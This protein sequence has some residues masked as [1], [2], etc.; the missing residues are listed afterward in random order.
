MNLRSR[1]G[2]A[3]AAA[4]AVALLVPQAALAAEDG[5]GHYGG[6]NGSGQGG[7]GQGGGGAGEDG[8]KDGSTGSIYSDLVIALRDAKGVP[9]LKEYDVPATEEEEAT[10]E[11]CVQPVSYEPVPGLTAE[12]NPVDQ[13]DV[14]V[15]PLQGEWWTAPPA[16]GLP[17]EEI[18]T[19]DPQPQYAMFVHEAELERL[20]MARTA[21]DVIARKQADV[22]EKLR[23]G[24][25]V[26]LEAA[27][28]ITIDGEMLD[29]SPEYAGIYQSLMY[30]GTIPGLQFHV[31]TAN[32]DA[33]KAAPPA[34]I[35]PD[36]TT[37]GYRN[38]RFDAWELAATAIGVAASK[39]M[40]I[41]L[42]AVIYYNQVIGF[43]PEETTAAAA[44]GTGGT[45]G[46]PSTEEP[47]QIDEDWLPMI[48]FVED[49]T[50]KRYVDYTGFSYN[51]ADTFPGS[52]TILNVDKMRWEVKPYIGT[53]PF[54]NLSGDK[55]PDT[56]TLTGVVAFAQLADDVRSLINYYHVIE[57][58]PG[59]YMD[60]VG[61]DTTAAQLKRIT[62]PAVDLGT[63]PSAVFPTEPFPVTASL[64]NPWGGSVIEQTNLKVTVDAGEAVLDVG[65][66]TAVS[67]P[68]DADPNSWD[69]PFEAVSGD[70]V[71]YWGPAGGFQ[72]KPGDKYVT[73]F[74]AK[75]AA[76]APVGDYSVTLELVGDPT[77]ATPE[78]GI[79]T[80]A[81]DT[82]TLDVM[83]NAP[84]V[85][86]GA[87][88]PKLLTQA[89]Q[90][91]LP[92]RVYEPTPAPAPEPEATTTE[93]RVLQLTITGPDD[94]GVATTTE[95][96]KATDVRIYGE[97]VKVTQTTDSA[98]E[99]D[100][101][102]AAEA[103]PVTDMARMTLAP[104]SDTTDNKLVG[105]W[106][107]PWKVGYSD[108]LWYVSVIDGA[109][110]GTYQFDL[111]L[112]GVQSVKPATQVTTV[113]A[114]AEHGQKPPGTGEDDGG[115]GGGPVTPPGNGS[116]GGGEGDD[117][118]DD[119]G[120]GDGGG[121]P[122]TPP[123][124]G[125]DGPGKGVHRAGGT[126]KIATGVLLSQ[127]RFDD[128]EADAAVIARSDDY[129]DA[130]AAIPLVDAENATLLLAGSSLDKRVLD[131]VKRAVAAN[132]T[133]YIVGGDKAVSPKVEAALK[134]TGRKVVR[135]AGTTRYA[136]AVKVAGA[137]GT[138][139]AILLATGRDFA[140]ALAGGTAAAHLDGV[141]LLTDG[142]VM[143]KATAGYLAQHRTKAAY[144]L[145]GPA[146]AAAPKA[147]RVVGTDRYDTA[148]RVA[149]RFF[150]NP[151]GASVAAGTRFED[152]LSGGADAAA[153]GWPLLLTMPDR[154]HAATA[155]Y[156]T[157][158]RSI[159]AVDVY[160]GPKA[161][162]EQVATALGG[163]LTR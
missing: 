23:L 61:I 143:P 77:E 111:E 66:V 107:V 31:D 71:G 152:A 16:G 161:I 40:P 45:G 27:G 62:D 83:A 140:D 54:L 1:G 101:A 92:V 46:S 142:K 90:L 63:L 99:A 119:D 55:N 48:K 129:A 156:V 15:I 147:T 3:L 38:S 50:G 76:D 2:G 115:D 131:E 10:T 150:K 73:T 70:L 5:E 137:L 91:Q 17:V 132:G 145:G 19:C 65:D 8:G 13:R 68:T 6:G 24:S 96:L 122:A 20:N 60:P 33:P 89:A 14:Y 149:Q 44:E 102:A 12:K 98:A 84:T 7:G 162:H 72:V 47:R 64:F 110:V 81:T 139:K 49:T 136:T 133:V 160:G 79:K 109:P 118:D 159:A 104:T 130:L 106:T 80:L 34:E 39:T 155:K 125:S 94:D 144:A 32:P 75:L 88:I 116:G 53:V 59:I 25:D 158:T 26:A 97:Q 82:D 4:L 69:L 120:D 86:W 67:R 74:D 148:V 93:D 112:L 78:A 124:G 163:C 128:G 108:I 117:G 138:P 134:A 146:A 135:L 29:A 151:A 57:G 95:Q 85:L 43:P 153:Q 41:S 42:D 121:G 56:E 35:G 154:L 22:E 52:M 105:T 58:I 103:Q 51:R 21:D 28:R 30:S 36:A 123:P 113:P 141:L 87:T 37:H 9:V 126:D 11:Y 127:E 114:P 18:E 100:V 157:E